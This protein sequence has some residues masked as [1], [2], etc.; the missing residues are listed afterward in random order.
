MS[1]FFGR[2]DRTEEPSPESE[3]ETTADTSGQT[4]GLTD[5]EEGY[6]PETAEAHAITCVICQQPIEPGQD[7]VE[8]TYGPVHSENCAAQTYRGR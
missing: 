6:E 8:A 3:E 4:V 2:G 1:L 7:F 5:P